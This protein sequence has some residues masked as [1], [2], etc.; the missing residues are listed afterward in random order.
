MPLWGLPSCGCRHAGK[1]HQT[2]QTP[3]ARLGAAAMTCGRTSAHHSSRRAEV[4]CSPAHAAAG[5]SNDEEGGPASRF[6][7]RPPSFRDRSHDLLELPPPIL[8][9]AGRVAPLARPMN[10]PQA[11]VQ[12]S[13]HSN[14]RT[15]LSFLSGLLPQPVTSLRR[16]R[17]ATLLASRQ[18]HACL[19]P[20]IAPARI[21]ARATPSPL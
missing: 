2:Q 19:I 16:P 4:V 15:N 13:G 14:D 1:A 7:G 21:D 20:R 8:G 17:R 18:D 12:T 9:H 5:S 6:K 3:S 10:A 11:M